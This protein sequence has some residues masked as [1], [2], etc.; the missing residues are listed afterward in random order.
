MA[1]FSPAYV[2]VLLTGLVTTVLTIVFAYRD[3]KTLQQRGVPAPFSWVWIFMM[4][5]VSS[6]VYII[7]RDVVARRRT[8]RWSGA[9]WVAITV[10]VVIFVAVM[11]S[12]FVRLQPFLSSLPSYYAH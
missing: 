3:W 9:A 4:F 2:A 5:A 10:T 7:G 8:G 1:L 11:I 6:L 12:F